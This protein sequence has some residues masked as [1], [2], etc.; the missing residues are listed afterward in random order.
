MCHHIWHQRSSCQ[1]ADTSKQ[2]KDTYCSIRKPTDSETSSKGS[3]G[4]SKKGVGVCVCTAGFVKE[5]EV[6]AAPFQDYVCMACLYRSWKYLLL[7]IE[8]HQLCSCQSWLM[9]HTLPLVVEATCLSLMTKNWT[10]SKN[11][12][13]EQSLSQMSNQKWSGT[14]R[15]ALKKYIKILQL[16]GKNSYALVCA[17]AHLQLNPTS[18]SLPLWHFLF[19]LVLYLYCWKQSSVFH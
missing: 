13:Q 19:C 14:Y 9:F 16:R 4:P 17:T 8:R 10:R 11:L 15:T 2:A 18:S 12:L 1:K 7:Y 6:F 3:K 5:L